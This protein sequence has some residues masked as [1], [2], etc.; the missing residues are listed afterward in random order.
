MSSYVL[1]A[2]YSR[3]HC[4]TA[5]N[6]EC[7]WKIEFLILGLTVFTAMACS[8]NIIVL[9]YFTATM[10]IPLGREKQ[11]NF[12]NQPA[13][14]KTPNPFLFRY[15]KKSRRVRIMKVHF[16]R[17]LKP[18]WETA[19]RN[20]GTFFQGID[21]TMG[22]RIWS[23]DLRAKERPRKKLRTHRHADMATTRP[24]CPEG[25]VGEKCNYI[26]IFSKNRPF[27]RYLPSLLIQFLCRVCTGSRRR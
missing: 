4:T 23:C 1:H 11:Y 22:Y 24:T 16:F 18:R 14:V 13:P 12:L 8:P 7:C 15:K 27:I 10:K 5:E 25:Q 6:W 26:F 2:V 9:R 17:L 3:V 19:S 20:D 21:A